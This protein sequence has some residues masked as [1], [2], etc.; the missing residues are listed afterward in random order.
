MVEQ[1]ADH[2]GGGGPDRLGLSPAVVAGQRQPGDLLGGQVV[3]LRHPLAGLLGAVVGGHQLVVVGRVNLHR[4]G[5]A[6]H[7]EVRAHQAVRR[8][9]IRAREGE[10]AVPVEGGLLPDAQVIGRGRQGAQGGPFHRLKALQRPALRR[11]VEALPGGL[12]TPDDQRRVA[13]LARLQRPAGQEVAFEVVDPALFRFSFQPRGP[14]RLGV[15]QKAVMLG[16]LAVDRWATG[17]VK[18]ALTMAAL[19]LSG[20][21]FAGTAPKNSKAWRWQSSQVSLP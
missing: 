20:T 6:A 8:G 16:A 17:S 21:I 3:Q 5:A 15:D 2:V 14:W 13:L 18:L 19:R 12:P 4:A 7:P 10:V 11:S 1:G 9:I